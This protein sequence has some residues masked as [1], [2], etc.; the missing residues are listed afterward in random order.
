MLMQLREAFRQDH[1]TVELFALREISIP[2]NFEEKVVEKVVVAQTKFT[3]D[4]IKSSR[5]AQANITVLQG[6]G[7]ATVN[8][9]TAYAEAAATIVVAEA[10]ADGLKAVS[11]EQASSFSKLAS[12]LQLAPEPLLKYQY[13]KLMGNMEDAHPSINFMLGFKSPMLQVS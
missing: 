6:Q 13:A 3:E 12:A 1:V 8:L 4:W 5:L 10:S 9:I 11:E 2:S 7:Q